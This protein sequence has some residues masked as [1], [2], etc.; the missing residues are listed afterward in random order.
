MVS[1]GKSIRSFQTTHVLLESRLVFSKRSGITFKSSNALMLL[2]SSH[3]TT[4]EPRKNPHRFISRIQKIDAVFI[5]TGKDFDH[6]MHP[7]LRLRGNI[8]HEIHDNSKI[9]VTGSCMYSIHRRPLKNRTPSVTAHPMLQPAM[10]P[11]QQR[12]KQPRI[13]QPSYFRLSIKQFNEHEDLSP[14]TCVQHPD[15]S[16]HLCF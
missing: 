10:Q 13:Q 7:L 12:S 9:C 11:M 4:V 6:D 1:L 3:D 14:A 16:S 15:Q 8:L 5:A 2:M